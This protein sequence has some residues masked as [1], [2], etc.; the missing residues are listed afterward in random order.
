M[1]V[2]L[3]PPH[4]FGRSFGIPSERCQRRAQERDGY[5]H[6]DQHA[7][8]FANRGFV[9]LDQGARERLFSV[10]EQRFSRLEAAGVECCDY[11]CEGQS[12]ARA[13]HILGKCCE[14]PP[15]RLALTSTE[16]LLTVLLNQPSCPHGFACCQG[17]AHRITDQSILLVPGSGLSMQFRHPLGIDGLQAGE[18]QIGKEMMVAIPV[19][20]LIERDQEQ[21]GSFQVFQ[22]LLSIVAIGERITQWATELL[23]NRGLEEESSHIVGL[24]LKYLLSQV[25][26]NV[27]MATPELLNKPCRI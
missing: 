11:L 17:M 10:L 27:A 6:V 23:K 22:H 4:Q 7:H 12:W 8:L 24:S 20:L 26:E 3:S 5:G 16:D 13:H 25:I 9:G 1:Q 18:E 2:G 19:A 14:P 15:E 21:V